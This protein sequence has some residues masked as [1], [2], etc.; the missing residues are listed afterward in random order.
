MAD[1]PERENVEIEATGDPDLD[2]LQIEELHKRNR[3]LCEQ[4]CPNGCGPMIRFADKSQACNHCGF[5]HFPVP[6]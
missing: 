1:Y 4:M 5:A 2:S 6:D 3:R